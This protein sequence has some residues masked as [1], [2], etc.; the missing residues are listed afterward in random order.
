MQ[1]RNTHLMN[2]GH[3]VMNLKHLGLGSLHRPG[4]LL[5]LLLPHHQVL[6]LLLQRSQRVEQG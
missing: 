2:S 6:N 4:V 1:C 3:L 5:A